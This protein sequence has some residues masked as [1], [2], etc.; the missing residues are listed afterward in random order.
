MYLGN[1]IISKQT[2]WPWYLVLS[3]S[4][5]NTG[6]YYFITRTIPCG[7]RTE[8]FS[9]VHIVWLPYGSGHTRPLKTRTFEYKVIHSGGS[10]PYYVICQTLRI[11]GNMVI[12]SPTWK[13]STLI[14]LSRKPYWSHA[15]P[16]RNCQWWYTCFIARTGVVWA[17]YCSHMGCLG[18]RH[19]SS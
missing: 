4:H 7:S 10:C 5:A 11:M 16:I 17:P 8:L 14:G 15:L 2:W 6:S 3:R 1:I 13:L 19:V 18:T 12:L 9:V